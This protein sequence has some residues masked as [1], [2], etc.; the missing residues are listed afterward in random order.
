MKLDT[1]IDPVVLEV[2]DTAALLDTTEF[3]IFCLAYTRWFGRGASV[4]FIEP[5][6][7][8]YM[9]SEI[10]PFWVHHFTRHIMNLYA[11]GRLNPE[12]Y[13][14]KMPPASARMIFLGRLYAFLLILILVVL[15]VVTSSS[16][17]LVSIAKNCYFPPCY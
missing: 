14:L 6:F 2:L 10:V 12:D 15:F 3:N 4:E 17:H 1:E 9:F 8:A 5:H 11:T 13:G 16:E 7:N